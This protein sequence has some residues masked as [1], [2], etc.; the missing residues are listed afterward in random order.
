MAVGPHIR[1]LGR[2]EGLPASLPH[3]AWAATPTQKDSS[4]IGN[5]AGS[6][7][8]EFD[9]TEHLQIANEIIIKVEYMDT[10]SFSFS[11]GM[12]AVQIEGEQDCVRGQLLPAK[13]QSRGPS[14]VPMRAGSVSR[15]TKCQ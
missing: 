10:E 6:V 15:G 2:A 7:R 9:Y 14:I 1:R 12:H 11:P 5:N 4:E 13:P 8:L 3:P